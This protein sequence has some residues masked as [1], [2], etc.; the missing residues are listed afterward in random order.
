M[1]ID[2]E[3]DARPD[4]EFVG[5]SARNGRRPVFE[6]SENFG[7]DAFVDLVLHARH[8]SQSSVTTAG[9]ATHVIRT[10]KP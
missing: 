8:D 4:D 10:A 6:A 7:L 2:V 1:K 3:V 5:G 9:F